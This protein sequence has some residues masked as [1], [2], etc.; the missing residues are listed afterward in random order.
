MLMLLKQLNAI[1]KNE[2]R[3]KGQVFP[4]LCYKYKKRKPIYGVGATPLTTYGKPGQNV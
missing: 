3:K 4:F 2:I 1:F